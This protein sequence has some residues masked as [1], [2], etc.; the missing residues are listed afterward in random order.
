MLG[1][2]PTAPPTD[3]KDTGGLFLRL[4][5]PSAVLGQLLGAV[6]VIGQVLGAVAAALGTHICR[7]LGTAEQSFWAAAQ[8]SSRIAL[9]GASCY[10]L[11]RGTPLPSHTGP[12]Q[13]PSY[14]VLF[15]ICVTAG[16]RHTIPT[17]SWVLPTPRKDTTHNFSRVAA[18]LNG[19]QKNSR[20]Q[21]QNPYHC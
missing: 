20:S 18:Q 17:A 11:K 7:P 1:W 6:A 9:W 12:H 15:P 13:S 21:K 2:D 19:V 14:A 3:Q 16:K 4:H 5:L 8:R 10:S